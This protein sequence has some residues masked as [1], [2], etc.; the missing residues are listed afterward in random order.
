MK[1]LVAF[2]GSLTSRYAL[3]KAEGMLR[4]G[5]SIVILSVA[6]EV[7]SSDWP[8]LSE[9]DAKVLSRERLVAV[10]RAVSSIS[11]D[12][13][14][15]NVK[16]EVVVCLAWDIA[17]EIVNQSENLGADM[18]VLGHRSADSLPNQIKKYVIIKKSP[19]KFI[20]RATN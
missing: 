13:R 6:E 8:F 5:D 10:Q 1:L 14:V 18:L 2:D 7:P 12:L 15:R 11:D 19:L 16:H 17:A 4:Q 9:D 20:N 3:D